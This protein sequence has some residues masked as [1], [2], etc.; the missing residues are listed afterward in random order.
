MPPRTTTPT[1]NAGD[2]LRRARELSGMHERAAA[3]ALGVRRSRIR[4]WESG[5]VAPDADELS[6]AI[7]LYSADLDSI[8]PD[9]QPLVSPEEPG[10]LVVGDER[11]DVRIDPELTPDGVTFVD[12]R[13]VLTRY[14]AA[15]RRQRGL[16]A[17]DPVE[18]R[19]N[20][21]ASLASVLDLEDGRLESELAELLDLT[22]AGARWTTRAM[23]VG[24]LMAVAATAM[25]G[26]SWFS[27]AAPAGATTVEVV[28][29]AAATVTFAPEV[30]PTT[31]V[32]DR[33]A[34]QFAPAT[35]DPDTPIDA[36]IVPSATATNP[37]PFSTE[38]SATPV[39]LAPA[40]FAVAP[41]T[42][43]TPVVDAATATLDAPEL[44]PG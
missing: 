13:V 31:E 44:P 3:R 22:P 9:R 37:S 20:D 12:N 32:S 39:E 27:S 40:V 21:I 6:R 23:V 35:I 26:T 43:W 28:A 34:V 18:L 41:S 7:A 14:L 10:V 4:D 33:A 24:A 16:G 17:T 38:P 36:E 11:I 5:A 30:T 15:V 25:V 8:W 42:E 19:A 2:M 1:T 29:P